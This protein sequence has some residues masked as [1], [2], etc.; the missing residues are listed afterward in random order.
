MRGEKIAILFWLI[1]A[2]IVYAAP[3]E[4]GKY[5]TPKDDP[6]VLLNRSKDFFDK[7]RLRREIEEEKQKNR[8]GIETSESN[9]LQESSEGEIKF[10]LKGFEFSS[11]EVLTTEELNRLTAPYLQKEVSINDLYKLINEINILYEKKGY[12]VC[13]AVLPPQTISSG[14]V[15]II[16]IEGKTGRVL[17]QKNK[18]TKD[19][20][21]RK[22]IN[23]D[24]GTVSNLNELNK[25]LI[26]FNG[27]NDV[28]MRIE[29]RA[30]EL[31][32]TTDYVL[33]A[34]EPKRQ[35]GVI[36]AD[37]SGSETSGEYRLGGSYI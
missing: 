10:K 13:K 37:N 6:G 1:L 9:R 11:S 28:Q 3:G 24:I 30:G 27:T 29:L 26:W 14:I 12:I 20:Y 22:R 35:V 18:S 2:H 21:I 36:F 8:T 16:L 32:G 19:N 34:Y 4:Y 23:L 7:Q 31:S 33:T 5:Y 17:I 15:K 25:S